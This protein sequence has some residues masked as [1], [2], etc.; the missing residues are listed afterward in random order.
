[1]HDIPFLE[2]T[3]ALVS[4]VLQ[5]D[6][7][8]LAL[9]EIVDDAAGAA[10]DDAHVASCTMSPGYLARFGGETDDLLALAPCV[11]SSVER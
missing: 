11:F 5:H 7:V 10:I 1:M 2:R 8:A 6:R 3:D 4:D 9:V